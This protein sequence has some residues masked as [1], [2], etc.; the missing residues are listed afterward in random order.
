MPDL[1]QVDIFGSDIFDAPSGC[2]YGEDS[3]YESESGSEFE[4]ELE[5]GSESEFEY[6]VV[7]SK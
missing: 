6:E 1:G 4:S 7:T 5:F 3:D 2:Y